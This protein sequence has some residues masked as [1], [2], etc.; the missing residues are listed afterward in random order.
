[1][2]VSLYQMELAWRRSGWEAFHPVPGTPEGNTLGF[3]RG[4]ESTVRLW[5]GCSA[6]GGAGT[7]PA[8]PCSAARTFARDLAAC[9]CQPLRLTTPQSEPGFENAKDPAKSRQSP[10]CFCGSG[11]QDGEVRKPCAYAPSLGAIWFPQP[12]TG[13][14]AASK[15]WLGSVST[16]HRQQ[17]RGL[18]LP[19]LHRA[20]WQQVE[21]A[22]TCLSQG[23]HSVCSAGASH[24]LSPCFVVWRRKG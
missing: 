12:S 23:L 20:T 19:R 10:V 21:I 1:M 9:T 11:A 2:Q 4:A 24:L 3:R 17:L 22:E 7:G 15:V 13:H 8:H 6:E 14:L 16:L 18:W 5:G